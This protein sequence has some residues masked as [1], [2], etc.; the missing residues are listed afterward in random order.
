MSRAAIVAPVSRCISPFSPHIKT[1]LGCKQTSAPRWK[2][3]TCTMLRVND[4]VETPS[5]QG[6]AH[7]LSSRLTHGCRIPILPC[8][9]SPAP[10]P[11]LARCRRRRSLT[12]PRPG[13]MNRSSTSA[14]QV[15][16]HYLCTTLKHTIRVIREF[17]N[18]ALSRG[19]NFLRL[20]HPKHS[21]PMPHLKMDFP[22][23][24]ILELSIQKAVGR[25]LVHCIEYPSPAIL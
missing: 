23:A 9:F 18:Y 5:L 2:S 10:A 7:R 8:D 17:G 21:S 6:E 13:P 11:P 25:I 4:L 3:A 1:F 12:V 20:L 19:F 22:L 15:H 16:T 24:A 14:C